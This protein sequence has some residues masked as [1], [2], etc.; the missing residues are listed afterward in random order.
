[1]IIQHKN[2][3]ELRCDKLTCDTQFLTTEDLPR[4]V[5]NKKLRKDARA[6]GWFVDV[7]KNHA[8]CPYCR[9]GK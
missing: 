4:K 1:M 2:S 8:V 3:V 5:L 7:K 6:M 9:G